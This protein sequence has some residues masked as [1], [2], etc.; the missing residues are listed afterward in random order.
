MSSSLLQRLVVR[1]AE[2][3]K[4]LVRLYYPLVRSW[5]ARAGLQAEDAADVAQ[6]V[7]RVLAGKV[8]AFRSENGAN[9]FRGWVYGITQKQLLAH[10]RHAREQPIGAGGTEAARRWAELREDEQE[11]SSSAPSPHDERKHLLRRALDLLRGDVEER[12]WQAFWRAA[13]E[14]HAPADIARDLGLSVNS[15]YL[16][17]ARLLKRLREEFDEL[18]R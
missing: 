18:C 6:E 1:D 11:D 14:G 9:S 2:A 8:G 7:F 10:R 13:I 3:W 15:V 4:R 5:C 16:A 12:T 17:K